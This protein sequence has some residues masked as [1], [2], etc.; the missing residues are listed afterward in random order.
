MSII[1]EVNKISKPSL[2]IR[3]N[4]NREL[5]I[6]RKI[7]FNKYLEVLTMFSTTQKHY[8]TINSSIFLFIDHLLRLEIVLLREKRKKKTL[9]TKYHKEI[10]WTRKCIDFFL[11]ELFEYRNKLKMESN[12]VEDCMELLEK[13]EQDIRSW[14]VECLQK[15]EDML[16]KK[17]LFWKN[18]KEIKE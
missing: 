8:E 13:K 1:E 3:E 4:T 11:D 18:V 2:K 12:L 9:I 15:A 5:N 14:K 17:V 6:I 7:I 16:R 10:Y